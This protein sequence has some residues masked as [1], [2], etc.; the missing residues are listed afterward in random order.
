MLHLDARIHFHEVEITV[1]IHQKLNGAYA[2]VLH[3][4]CRLDGRFPHFLAE[5]VGHVRRRRF[6]HQ[7]LVAA[8]DGTIALREVACLAAL[9][10]GNLDLDVTRLDDELLHVHA[11]IAKC[12]S[13][14]AAGG[15]PSFGEAFVIVAHLHAFSSATSS[16]F[17]HDG[18]AN[19]VGDFSRFLQ[20]LEDALVAGNGRHTSGLHG[21]LG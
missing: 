9:V 6:L 10:G 20:A 12:R 7:L 15:F 19:F 4:F 8:L 3:G 14:F 2:L 18:V 11:V 5:F 21:G 17:Q 13:C 16:G 1:G